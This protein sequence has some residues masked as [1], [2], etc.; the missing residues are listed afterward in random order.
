MAGRAIAY[1]FFKVTPRTHKNDNDK[2]GVHIMTI[3]IILHIKICET[4]LL[5]FRG[6]K[7]LQY[8]NN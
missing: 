7:L 5:R 3:S 6:P 1:L 8:Y 4:L 2:S